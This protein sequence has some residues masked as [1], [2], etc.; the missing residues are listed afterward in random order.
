MLELNGSVTTETQD[1]EQQ[2]I[3]RHGI[4]S[5]HMSS[6]GKKEDSRMIPWL[7]LSVRV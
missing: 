1:N 4:W 7:L 3:T 5:D 6:L 2:I